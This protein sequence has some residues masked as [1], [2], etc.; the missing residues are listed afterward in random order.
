MGHNSQT[1]AAEPKENLQTTEILRRQNYQE[2]LMGTLQGIGGMCLAGE[3]WSKQGAEDG[4]KVPIHRDGEQASLSV[5]GIILPPSHTATGT[6]D[7]KHMPRAKS[8][9]HGSTEQMVA[10]VIMSL[11]EQNALNRTSIHIR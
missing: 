8:A 7:G 6:A 4:W 1:V 9:T 3:D 5:K 2:L 11:L 10:V